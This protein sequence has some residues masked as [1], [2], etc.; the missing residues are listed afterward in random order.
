LLHNLCLVLLN[1]DVRQVSNITDRGYLGPE[2]T[3]STFGPLLKSKSQNPKATLLALFLNAIH[4]EESYGGNVIA[5][6][7]SDKER[8]RKYLTITQEMFTR[9]PSN[10][11]F[12]RFI[13]ASAMFRD[14]DEPF[15]RFMEQC[16]LGEISAFNG[17][18]VKEINS[19]VR[20]W[21]LRLGKTAT[22]EEFDILHASSHLGSERYVEWERAI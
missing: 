2:L 21:P 16:R 3:L 18:R 6:L 13:E 22:K 8:M 1:P 20:P 9:G 15:R 7:Q 10:A 19:I 4:E 11:D 12:V 17:L 14:F 5:S